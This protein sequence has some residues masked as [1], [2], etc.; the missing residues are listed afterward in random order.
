MA[1]IDRV[2]EETEGQ[3]EMADQRVLYFFALYLLVC[4]TERQFSP[5]VFIMKIRSF[6]MELR[7]EN[8]KLICCNCSVVKHRFRTHE[9]YAF[10]SQTIN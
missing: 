5:G 8:P 1:S 2:A 3:K 7:V 6:T 9:K 10:H 4:M